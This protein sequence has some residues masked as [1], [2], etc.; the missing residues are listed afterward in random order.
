MRNQQRPRR[1]VPA[2][3]IT[4][5]RPVFRYSPGRGAY[6]LRIGGSRFGPVLTHRQP[7]ERGGNVPTR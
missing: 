2:P 7:P 3:W 4:V 6:V 5:L 1:P